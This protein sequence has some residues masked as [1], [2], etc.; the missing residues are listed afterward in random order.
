MYHSG[1]ELLDPYILFE[2]GQLQP[3]MHAADFGCG[4]TGHIIFPAATVVGPQ[5]V[6]FAVDI[7][8]DALHAIEKRAN[9][10]GLTN[11]HPVWSNVEYVG[12]TAIPPGSL[13]VVFVVNVLSHSDNRHGMLEEAKRLLKKKGRIIVA[14]WTSQGLSIAPKGERFV[15]FENIKEW[16]RLHGFAVQAEFPVG[17]YHRGVALYRNI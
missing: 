9:M 15:D 13:D 16:G 11:I 7:L 3:G 6:L 10:E 2:K 12:K 5:G 8:K 17:K 14:D 4:R 1:N